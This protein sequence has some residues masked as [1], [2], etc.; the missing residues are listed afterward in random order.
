M[1]GPDLDFRNQQGDGTAVVCVAIGTIALLTIDHFLGP[2][3]TAL[4][5]AVAGGA[6]GGYVYCRSL[7]KESPKGN[8]EASIPAKTDPIQSKI[9]TS[10]VHKKTLTEELVRRNVAKEFRLSFFSIKIET[11]AEHYP[12]KLIATDSRTNQF[13]FSYGLEL[14]PFST[15]LVC[16][17]ADGSRYNMGPPHEKVNYETF[18]R[19]AIDFTITRIYDDQLIPRSVLHAIGV[20]A[21]AEKISKADFQIFAVKKDE[22]D[23]PQ[24]IGM[25]DGVSSAV[26]VRADVYPNKGELWDLTT[27][28]V[29][30]LVEHHRQRGQDLYYAS[31]M[32]INA[33]ARNDCEKQVLLHNGSYRMSVEAFELLT[34]APKIQVSEGLE[35]EELSMI[36]EFGALIASALADAIKLPKHIENMLHPEYSI[37]VFNC[38]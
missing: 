24:I 19:L 5:I 22:K 37:L 34:E 23:G 31:V 4:L 11:D 36:A 8:A 1:S 18:E 32:L 21:L 10:S 13:A 25:K 9:S 17:S 27:V 26:I 7:K 20:Q 30:R 33:E 3:L 15:C 35:S 16:I 38:I 2:V 29:E 12:F 6:I 28:E 14:S